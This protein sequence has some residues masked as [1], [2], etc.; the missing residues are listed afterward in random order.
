[1]YP[2]LF[3]IGDFAI[4]SFGVM[5]A[6]AF[7]IGG[8]ILS[9][10]LQRKGDNPELAW[11]LVWYAAI[12]GVVGARLYYLVLTWPQTVAD[13]WGA[14]TSRGGLVWYGGLIGASAL[15][16]WRLHRANVPVLRIADA[17]APAL[18]V[19]YAVG[20]LGCFLVGDDYGR[21]SDV[22]WAIAFPEGAPP[23]TAENLREQFGVPIPPGVPGDTVLAVH[24]TQL[25]EIA[26]SLI[27]FAIVWRLRERIS[28][29]G[30]LFAIYIALA[31]IERFIVEIFRAKDDRFFGAFTMAQ[32]I[33]IA[34]VIAGVVGAAY[35]MS[36]RRD[37]DGQ[38]PVAGSSSA[39]RA[40]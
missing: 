36:R 13:P 34:L 6:L 23:S 4:T 8:W 1:M 27:I 16:Y 11:E 12:G 21:P 32:L 24:P 9:K 30:A 22:P 2:V 14:I 10:E 25:Y 39:G 19:A 37:V 15:I 29:A 7:L 5:M 33:S 31:G 38:V 18:A 40:R 28:P 3:R 35:L 20:R 26:M 17:V